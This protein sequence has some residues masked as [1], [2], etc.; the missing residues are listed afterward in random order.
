[1]TLRST[2]SFNNVAISAIDQPTSHFNGLSALLLG[3][4]LARRLV[5]VT[6][7]TDPLRSPK[8]N[9]TF[10]SHQPAGQHNVPVK[11]SCGLYAPSEADW[12]AN[13]QL[14]Q[15]KERW[16][17]NKQNYLNSNYVFIIR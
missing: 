6:G 17:V 15:I 3:S 1:M 8:G 13:N 10:V 9:G 4:P 12:L 11:L 7:K 14:E 2:S 5:D 16:E